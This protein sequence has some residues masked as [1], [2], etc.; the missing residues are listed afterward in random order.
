MAGKN[1]IIMEKAASLAVEEVTF[2]TGNTTVAV[3]K[4]GFALEKAAFAAEKAAFFVQIRPHL[5]SKLGCGDSYAR[6][7][8]CMAPRL[9]SGLG[10]RWIS[11]TH[12]QRRASVRVVAS[13]IW[14]YVAL[15]HPPQV[16]PRPSG[17]RL[18]CTVM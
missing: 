5:P 16:R 10:L 15:Q 7:G 9:P 1:V 8:D 18:L 13:T 2:A 14:R 12:K 17:I 3:E 6:H 4:S 11:R